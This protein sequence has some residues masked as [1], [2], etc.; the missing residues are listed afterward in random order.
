MHLRS[1]IE[2]GPIKLKMDGRDH[3]LCC[4]SCKK[5]YTEK[6]A[7]IRAAAK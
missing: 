6:Y 3:Y 5:L 2:G 1:E 4:R 7:R